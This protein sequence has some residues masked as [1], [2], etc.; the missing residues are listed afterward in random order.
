MQ[1]ELVERGV[2][3]PPDQL[4]QWK[5]YAAICAILLVAAALVFISLGL[6]PS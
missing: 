1:D 4:P 6:I 3:L 5:F 2:D